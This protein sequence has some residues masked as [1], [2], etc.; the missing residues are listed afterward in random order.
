M[1]L[2]SPLTVRTVNDEP[3]R[4]SAE[5][6]VHHYLMAKAEEVICVFLCC[7]FMI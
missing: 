5:R 7:V 2:S 6:L 4:T 1:N 3:Q